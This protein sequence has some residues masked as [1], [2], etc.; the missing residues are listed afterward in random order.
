MSQNP[1]LT[2]IKKQEWL[3]PLQD[4]GSELVQKA[5]ESAGP[6]GQA[7]K[8]ALHGTWLGH[9][10]HAAITDVPV[11]SWTVAAVLDLLEMSG[12]RE[13]H[14]GADAAVMIGLAGAVPAA[15]SGLT[16]WSAIHGKPQRVGALHGLLNTGAA[17]LY[18]A[19][20][21]ARKADNRGLGRCLGFLGFGLVLASAYIGGELSYEQ[22]IG[23][24]HAPEP[25]NDLPESYV[26]AI[27]ASELEEDKPMKATVNG[28][29]IFLLKQGTTI[30]A[31]AN[32]CAHLG[33]PLSEG[34]LEGD[35]IV[36]PWHGSRFCVKTGNVEDGPATM[37]QPV[38]DVKVENGKVLVKARSS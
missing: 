17:A 13:Y 9:P 6:S 31:L 21:I 32:Q 4:K 16:D 27:A 37:N 3:K 5:F 8:N 22:K 35:S 15:L 2:A 18:I 29:P 11:G 14:A 7:A 33:G 25:D 26:E 30:H 38:L 28:T 23:V 19:S 10:L 12:S 34:K 20:S 1:V 36:C 24:N